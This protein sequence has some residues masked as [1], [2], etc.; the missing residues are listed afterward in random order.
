MAGKGYRIFIL[1]GIF[2]IL[3]LCKKEETIH[4]PPHIVFSYSP[5]KGLT[6]TTISFDFSQTVME[7]P[8]T[9]KVFFKWDWNGDGLWDT[10][11]SNN[12]QFEHRYLI[13]GNTVTK[14][15]AMDLSGLSDT[16]QFEIDIEQGYSKPRPH[17]VITPKMGTPY[18]RFRLDA[19]GTEDDED[20]IETLRF[21]WDINGDGEFDTGYTNE[22]IYYYQYSTMGFFQPTL[23]VKDPRGLSDRITSWIEVNLLDKSIIADFDWTPKSPVT[24]DT[25]FFDASPSH[26]SLFPERAMQYRWDWQND[27]IFDTPFSDTAQI[28]YSFIS[29]KKHPVRLEVK[30][31]RGLTNQVVKEIQVRHRNQPP[32][33]MFA[34]SSFG[35]N[36]L[37]R[38]R[39]DLW[40]SRD[41]ENSPSELLSRWDWNGDGVWDT[42][43]SNTMEV[44]HVFSE[45]GIY[46]VQLN[47]MDE[48]GLT[49]TVSKTIRIGNGTNQTD[50]L[51]DKRGY[52][53]WK[54]YGIVKIGD[55]WWFAKNMGIKG[56]Y[57]QTSDYNYIDYGRLYSFGELPSTCPDGW[58]IPTRKDWEKL[59]SQFDASTLYEDLLPG[60]KSGFNIALG[61]MLNTDVVPPAITGK[62]FYGYYWSDTGLASDSGQSHWVVTFDNI[63]H[64]VTPGFNPS[65]G[66]YSVRCVKDAN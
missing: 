55:Q 14:V 43:F 7:K 57:S 54:Y 8:K 51:L 22:S 2:L 24:D 3:T 45:P 58:R 35:G 53:G 60:G 23:E 49:D 46:P 50:I 15:I 6:T 4:I 1:I 38:I 5:Q 66:S 47:V 13:P 12:T 36:T 56:F 52:T 20:S 16:A 10:P 27:G 33:A 29:A 18:T 19:T 11:F 61:G 26:D 64:Q 62:G 41:P 65:I 44:F 63:N 32:I 28:R 40:D 59:F 39:F 37:T 17:L 9:N 21:R 48:G 31:Y 25:I 30:N 42:D 34:V